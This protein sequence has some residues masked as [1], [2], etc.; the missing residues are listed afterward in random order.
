[1]GKDVSSLNH[2]ALRNQRPLI[3][4][5]VL[6]GTGVLGEVINIYARLTRLGLFVAH[7]HDDTGRIDTLDHPAVL[8]HHTDTRVMCHVALQSGA[9]ERLLGAQGWHRLPLHVRAHQCTVGV[10]VLEEGNQGRCNGHH[11]L[12][13][14][15]HIIDL[16]AGHER[17]FTLVTHGHQVIHE[18]TVLV[19]RSTRLCNDEL[20]LVDRREEIDFISH[21]VVD[22]LAV[23]AYQKSVGIGTGIG[24][25]R[26]D[27]TDVRTLWRLDGT[28][29]TVV[30]RVYVAHFESSTLAREAAWPKSRYTAL[31]GNFGQR[32]VLVHELG[33]LAGTE[34]FLDRGSYRLRIDH[35]LRHQAFGIS[36]AQSLLHC[37]LDAYKTDTELILG[38]L[39]HRADATVTQVIDI[40]HRAK[41]VANRHQ[42]L[43]NVDAV[44]GA[45]YW[46]AFALGPAQ[47]AVELHA[48]D[49]G[50]VIALCREEQVGKQVLRG[51]LR[52]RLAG[53][54]HAIDFHQRLQFG[55]GGIDAQRLGNERTAIQLIGIDGLE[56][57]D[58]GLDDAVD[59]FLVQLR[60]AFVDNLAGFR[61][62]NVFCQGLAEE[63]LV[64]H[65]ELTQLRFLHLSDMAGSDATPLFYNDI[66]FLVGD[67]EVDHFAPQACWHQ[68]KDDIGVLAGDLVRVVLI[69]HRQNFLRSEI[70]RAQ[71]NSGRQ[72]ATTVDT[73]KYQV[74]GIEFE[75]QPGATVG[76]NAGGIQQLTG[77]VGLAFV[78]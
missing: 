72:L 25:Q 46:R 38:H 6:V 26:V 67:R 52:G 10:I 61:I 70:Q 53:A 44:V 48:A 1:L 63:E 41:T 24:R 64:A 34:E 11:L 75:I 5:G 71:Q 73:D 23:W 59:H 42:G 39:A 47:P 58:A 65:L 76:N 50:Q 77:T 28:Y 74:L 20:T 54:H 51:V 37:A 9:D 62:D 8:G 16:V 57:L 66:T 43:E 49:S 29:T 17:G 15:I 45:Q 69:E 19:Q 36:H 7:A 21:T 4:A 56:F 27:Q 12:G 32:V 13:R 14:H 78:V 55:I 30:S 3:D 33:Q 18:T 31:V 40:V 60:V 22:D 68:L 35:I 2:I